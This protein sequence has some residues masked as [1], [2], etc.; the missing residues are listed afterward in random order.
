MKQHLSIEEIAK[1]EEGCRR[2]RS[3]AIFDTFASLFR[4]SYRVI[5][6]LFAGGR[7]TYGRLESNGMAVR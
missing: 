4:G 5:T 3:A 6:S 2:M 7:K 1:L